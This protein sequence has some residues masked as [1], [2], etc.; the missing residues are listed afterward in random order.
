MTD[1]STLER[2]RTA[3]RD[4]AWSEAYGALAT[5]DREAALGAEDLERLAEAA[6]WSAHPAESVDAFERAHTAYV[7]EGNPERAAY[8]ALRLVDERFTRHEAALANGWRQRAIRLLEGRPETAVNGYLELELVRASMMGGDLAEAARHATTAHEIGT[9]FGDR[10]LEAFGLVLEGALLVWQAE[11]EQGLSKVDEAMAAVVA[12]ELSPFVGGNVYCVT[13]GTCRSVADY[14]RAGEWTEAAARWCERQRI[15]GFPGVCRVYR[16]EVMRIRGELPRAEDEARGALDELLAFERFTD[17]G[18]GSYEIGEIRLRLGDLD[19]AEDAFGR[20][21]ELGREPHPGM[22]LVHLARGRVDVARATIARAMAEAHDPFTR[23]RLL[24]ARVEIALAAHDLADAR[25]AADELRRLAET[26]GKP[27]LHAA[28]HQAVGV[29][30]TYEEDAPAAIAELRT[31]IRHWTEAGAPFE[32]AQARRWLALAY[33]ASGDEESAALELRAAKAVFERLGARLELERCEQML[34]AGGRA[35]AGRRVTRT[36]MFTDIVGSTSLIE[37]IGDEAWEDVARWHDE[38]LRTL[39]ASHGGEVVHS[40]GDGF[41]AAFGDPAAAAR[42]AVS[43]QQRLAEH[44]RKHGFAP[45]VRIGLHAAEATAMADDYA[46]L[47]VH[48]AARVGAAAEG[49]EIVATT[50]TIEGSREAFAFDV[51]DE[52]EVELKGLAHPVRVVSI[53]WRDRTGS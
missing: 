16:A 43:I 18:D 24:P 47:G 23:A 50:S 19:G 52:R 37:T 4:H 34:A 35:E 1:A 26:Y 46:G 27:M 11:V 32:A 8:V 30:L 9:R 13:M 31:A 33:R 38:T 36:F 40:T 17:A 2:A 42:S 7:A 44:R 49:D 10:D 41:F 29:A 53:D 51:A 22:A 48:E 14:R 45:R 12:G 6:W 15:T 5:L 28:A 3:L 25:D 20:A 21:N 39:I